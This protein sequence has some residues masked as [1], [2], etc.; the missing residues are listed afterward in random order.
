MKRFA[1][2]L[3]ALLT[4]AAARHFVT[5]GWLDVLLSAAGVIVATRVIATVGVVAY[6]QWRRWQR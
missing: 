4:I 1:L 2:L 3:V 6:R 5:V